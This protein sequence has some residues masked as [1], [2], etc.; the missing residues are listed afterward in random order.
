MVA[1]KWREK[2]AITKGEVKRDRSI[3]NRSLIKDKNWVEE[4]KVRKQKL[5]RKKK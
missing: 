2:G 5:E 3:A 1:R 4:A